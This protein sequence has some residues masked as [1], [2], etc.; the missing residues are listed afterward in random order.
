MKRA[1]KSYG[2]VSIFLKKRISGNVTLLK[3]GDSFV[4]LD[5]DRFFEKFEVEYINT[6]YFQNIKTLKKVLSS[7]CR[8]V[9]AENI[10]EK[11]IWLGTYYR[12]EILKG[13]SPSIYIKWIGNEKGYG[14]FAK[15]DLKRGSFIGN[16]SGVLRKHKKSLDRK[17]GYCFEYQT[18]ESKKTPFTVDAKYLGNHTRFINHGSSPNLALFNAYLMGITHIILMT[19]RD[20]KRDEELT[21]DY[22]PDYWKKRAKPVD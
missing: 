18:G 7:C 8:G 15:K 3:E 12:D 1:F 11:E 5:G 2:D 14:V 10:S 22:G 20:V 13:T 4:E 19:K 16:Y 17:N 6:L 21:Y 9:E